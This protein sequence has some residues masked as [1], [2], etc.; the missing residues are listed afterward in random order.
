MAQC[1]PV[2][3]CPCAPVL[4][5]PCATIMHS[6]GPRPP[7]RGTQECALASPVST[8]LPVHGHIYSTVLSVYPLA[9]STPHIVSEAAYLRVKWEVAE[10]KDIAEFPCSARHQLCR[11]T[12]RGVKS[13]APR[14]D[15]YVE[16][17]ETRYILYTHKHTVH[18]H[19][20]MYTI[21]VL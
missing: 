2:P 12:H 13:T 10:V 8:V 6:R 19:Y 5:C 16:P 7:Q 15:T 1:V 14:D 11:A 20:T 18:I 9:V 3:L 4:L 21:H 17:L